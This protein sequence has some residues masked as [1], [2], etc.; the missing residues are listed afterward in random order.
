M[1]HLSIGARWSRENTHGGHE[2]CRQPE[3]QR[4][5]RRKNNK[6]LGL[7]RL[8]ISNTWPGDD[9]VPSII[10]TLHES[11]SIVHLGSNNSNY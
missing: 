5:L 10:Q 9:H 3:D 4:E 7:H 2:T 6:G 1:L 8:Y 11:I